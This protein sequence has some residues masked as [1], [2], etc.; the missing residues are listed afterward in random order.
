MFVPSY[1]D[2]VI[3]FPFVLAGEIITFCCFI[4]FVI[5]LPKLTINYLNYI[6]SVISK[7]AVWVISTASE[8]DLKLISHFLDNYLG[9]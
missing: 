9:I 7:Q 5:A 3:T 4:M 8:G 6:Q 1:F 2:A